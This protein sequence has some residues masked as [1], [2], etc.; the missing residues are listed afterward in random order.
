M[1]EGRTLPVRSCV[2]GL[3]SR[4]ESRRDVIRVLCIVEVSLVAAH[5]GGGRAFENAV[6][7]TL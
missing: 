3:A 5:T 2:A 6:Y 1:I 4:R 7:V